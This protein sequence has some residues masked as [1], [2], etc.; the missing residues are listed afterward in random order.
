MKTTLVSAFAA[1]S[2][3]LLLGGCGLADVS[4]S[5][6]TQGPSAAE[7][8]QEAKKTQ[9]KVERQIEDAQQAAADI[10]A[11]AEADSQ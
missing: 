11:Q 8:A 1:F 9:E 7:Q 6:A 3:V 5:A 2:C 10:R 4:A